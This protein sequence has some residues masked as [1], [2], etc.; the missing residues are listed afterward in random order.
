MH[1]RQGYIMFKNPRQGRALL[2]AGFLALF[3]PFP[4]YCSPFLLSAWLYHLQACYHLRPVTMAPS[5]TL[6]QEDHERDKLFRQAM[7]G[8]T[9]QQKNAFM[10]WIGKNPDAQK[11]AVDE[12]FKYWD[13][14]EA[15]KETINDMKV[16]SIHR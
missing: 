8:K 2:R 16:H 3:Y 12:Y 10:N 15:G 1:C 4:C 9:A 14:K 6:E 11:A 7:H 5:A 13:K